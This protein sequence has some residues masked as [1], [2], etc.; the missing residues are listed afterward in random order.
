MSAILA[1]LQDRDVAPNGRRYSPA[2]HETAYLLWRTVC[3]RSARKVALRLGMADVTVSEWARNED[4]ISR[5]NVEDHDD[6][7]SSRIGVAAIVV[8]ELV[9]SI[10]TAREIRDDKTVAARDRL[11]AAQWLAGLAG[12]SPVSKIETAVVQAPTN[13]N[14]TTIIELIGKS[15]D[16]LMRLEE[17]VRS[18]HLP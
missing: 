18:K 14:H 8:N 17:S 5:A 2:D 11:A 10:E 9:P 16:E 4:W 13:S 7:A 3:G 6:Y 1:R 15:P 12:V